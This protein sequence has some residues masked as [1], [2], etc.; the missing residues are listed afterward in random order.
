MIEN[1]KDILWTDLN[2]NKLGRKPDKDDVISKI[3]EII[4]YLND[5]WLNEN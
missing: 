3:N 1:L 2:G 5:K 4:D